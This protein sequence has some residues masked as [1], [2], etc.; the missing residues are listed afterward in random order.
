MKYEKPGITLE[1]FSMTDP[2]LPDASSLEDNPILEGND[3]VYG[4]NKLSDAFS[5]VFD[6]SQK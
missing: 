1:L 3:P 4:N 2:I 5:E 6:I